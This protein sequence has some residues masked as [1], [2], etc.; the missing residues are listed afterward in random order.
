MKATIFL[1][2][3]AKYPDGSTESIIIWELPKPT[4]ERSH[5]YKYRLN[6]HTMNGTTLVRYDNSH[7]K[8]DHKHILDQIHPYKFINIEKLL[9]DFWNDVDRIREK[10]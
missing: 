8:S 5:G 7:G 3:E 2:D 1:A 4:K 10:S 6:Y 9:Y